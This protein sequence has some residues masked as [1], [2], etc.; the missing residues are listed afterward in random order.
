MMIADHDI[1]QL[2]R[3]DLFKSNWRPKWTKIG[4][5]TRFSVIF[6]SLLVFVEIACNDSLQE[7]QT[8]SRGK[9]HGKKIGGLKFGPKLDLKLGFL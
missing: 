8:S 5:E 3:P 4:P 9:I 7:C 1:L 6:S 2:T